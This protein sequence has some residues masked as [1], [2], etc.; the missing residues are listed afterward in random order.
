LSPLLLL[1]VMSAP[2][3]TGDPVESPSAVEQPVE[4]PPRWTRQITDPDEASIDA[5]MNA[6]RATVVNFPDEIGYSTGPEPAAD[7]GK[8]DIPRD[9]DEFLPLLDG[10]APDFEP[11]TAAIAVHEQID[12]YGGGRWAKERWRSNYRVSEHGEQ[13]HVL[14]WTRDLNNE[15]GTMDD[16]RD[17]LVTLDR[18]RVTSAYVLTEDGGWGHRRVEELYSFVYGE[19]GQLDGFDLVIS[20]YEDRPHDPPTHT[21]YASNWTGS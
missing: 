3:N 11:T 20:V 19:S 12:S 2:A 18:G 4:K 14:F 21:V 16:R 8:W 5:R 10:D 15:R 6:M 1:A 17:W 9:M 13:M 7:P